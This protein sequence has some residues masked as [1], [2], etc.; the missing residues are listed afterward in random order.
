MR[1]VHSLYDSWGYVIAKFHCN[2]LCDEWCSEDHKWKFSEAVNFDYSQFH[3]RVCK[4]TQHQC[5]LLVERRWLLREGSLMPSWM[6]ER[7][8]AVSLRSKHG[9]SAVFV[10]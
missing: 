2:K 5:L 7:S 1:N 8:K 10:V 6:E 9:T 4:H 3:L